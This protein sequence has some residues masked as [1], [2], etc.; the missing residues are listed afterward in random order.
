MVE[1]QVELKLQGRPTEW[2]RDYM[3]NRS[4]S[5]KSLNPMI[6][7]LMRQQYL[8][9]CRCYP[10]LGLTN[11]LCCRP[12]NRPYC[13]QKNQRRNAHQ[14][15]RRLNLRTSLRVIPSIHPSPSIHCQ[16]VIQCDLVGFGL[17][18]D[19]RIGRLPILP[20]YRLNLGRS[21]LI[22]PNYRPPHWQSLER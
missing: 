14:T 8:R 4:V 19:H 1:T 7:R 5:W 17:A 3:R 10:S 9:S 12:T 18:A 6:R 16:F 13:Y 22:P 20:S 15:N 21:H 11:H 2:R